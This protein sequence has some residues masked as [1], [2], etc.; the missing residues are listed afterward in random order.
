MERSPDDT[1]DLDGVALTHFGWQQLTE[2]QRAAMR[3]VL[4]GRDVL[5]VMP[6]GSGKSAIYQVPTLL[7]DG[8]TLVV[9][10]LI[11]LQHDQIAAI[12]D[13]GAGKAVAVN[14]GLRAAQLR[15]N[16]EAIDR[17]DAK[18]IFISPE[19]LANDE[20]VQRLSAVELSLLV[21]DEAHC[22][23]A[24]GHDFRP[25]YRR[26]ADVFRQLG[27]SI[28]V[29]ALTATASVVVRRDI[30]DRLGFHNP[31]IVVG[32]FDRPNLSLTVE[33]H[34]DEDDKRTAVLDTVP[35]LQGPGLLYVATRKDAEFY[36]QG[37]RDKGIAAAAYHAGMA[38]A[39]RDR[40]H[41][42]F[43]D[44]DYE[45]VVAT[46]AF[47]MGIDKPN[48]RFVVHA[49][50][51]DSLDSYYQQIGRAG[52]D[53]EDACALLLYRPEDLGLARFFT[54]G[55]PDEELL[56]AVYNALDTQRPTK[57]KDLRAK[58]DIPGRRLTN[59]INL[60][61]ESG[62][63]RSTRKGLL[64]GK[65]PAAEA[66]AEAVHMVEL[67]E[68]VDQSRIEMMRGYSETDSCRRIF[69]LSYFGEYLAQ[70]CGNC[71]CCE[72]AA[73]LGDLTA[74]G[75]AIPV[76]TAVQHRQWGPGVVIGGD[77]ERVTVLFD[78]FGYRTLS[79]AAVRDHGL[80]EVSTSAHPETA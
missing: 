76:D 51:P 48:V 80:L 8:V 59:G 7:M 29:V 74:E 72:Q 64:S 69:L 46:S 30:V 9:S 5:A 31:S 18:F 25:D 44:D 27:E 32:G 39:D 63:I 3:A 35:T 12:D 11:A 19:Q 75:P 68:R 56:E 54:T 61:D 6:T 23:S 50:I 14:S 13:C 57:P 4:N 16:W 43:R 55:S 28:P 15:R 33:R 67:R 34:L 71:D 21:V 1:A 22:V 47:G 70:P 10:P 78:E 17:G 20:V 41:E 52:R 77:R 38:K 65:L 49:S 66:V 26:L 58:L 37:L 79:M 36:A 42:G 2:D 62:A 24:W 53:G 40:V 60:L 45:V 73:E